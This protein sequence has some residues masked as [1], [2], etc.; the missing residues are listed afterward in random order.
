[1]Q[2]P[3]QDRITV[4]LAQNCP[5][6]AEPR[7]HGCEDCRLHSTSSKAKCTTLKSQGANHHTQASSLSIHR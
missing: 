7:R 5:S 4:A 6:L 2:T 3:N 1:M